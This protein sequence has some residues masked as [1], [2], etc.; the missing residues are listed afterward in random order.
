M[1][2]KDKGAEMGGPGEMRVDP[3]SV[4]V[5]NTIRSEHSHS[6]SRLSRAL[7]LIWI[8]IRSI[9]LNRKTIVVAA[10][11]IILL[12]V[13]IIWLMY[14]PTDEEE[15]A[16]EISTDNLTGYS[17][18]NATLT[19]KVIGGKPPYLYTWDFGDG[20]Q[21]AEVNPTHSYSQE[22]TY[23]VVLM[24]EDS[25]EVI[26]FSEPLTFL[27]Q[28]EFEKRGL[29]VVIS[30]NR[31]WGEVSHAV[32][33][34]SAVIGG[35][36][37]YLY[38]WD[39]GEG[40]APGEM[41][42]E[43]NFTEPGE[44]IVKLTVQDSQG[45]TSVS[46]ILRIVVDEESEVEDEMDF[47]MGLIVILYLQMIVL[48]VCFLYA[49]ALITSEVDDRTITYLIS[50]PIKKLEIVVYKYTGYIIS[51]FLIFSIPATINYG[52]LATNG[53]GSG[54]TDNL[55]FLMF[56]LGGILLGIILW[57]AFFILLASVFRNPLMPGF[58][59]C[60]FWESLIANIGTNVSKLTVTYQIRTFIINGLS[61][62]RESI[63]EEG[64]LPPHGDLSAPETFLLSVIVS[65]AFLVL[66]G[67]KLRG[68]DF[69]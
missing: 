16:V 52:I 43:F 53:G 41:D 6:I 12:A 31:T 10:I 60:I 32:K 42:P 45:N 55:D 64:D 15:L 48:Y 47:F 69:Y 39:L 21:S 27:V 26:A 4:P 57:G 38:N 1:M 3:D 63:A 49:S 19:S 11:L 36:A 61:E 35:E 44:F 33:F 23:Q 25:E 56:S 58:L 8:T 22:G 67:I 34:R 37:P 46:N 50:R 14:P 54:L 2:M 9:L 28:N 5:P 29:H 59:F 13:P 24:I 65:I 40:S 7:A 62:L 66:A 18:F 68:R 20:Y 51:L 30:A 17:P